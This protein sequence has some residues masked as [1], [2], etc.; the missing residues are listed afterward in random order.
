MDRNVSKI[1]NIEIFA[2]HNHCNHSEIKLATI[3]RLEGELLCDGIR[4]LIYMKDM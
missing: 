3:F 1:L 4:V 2:L